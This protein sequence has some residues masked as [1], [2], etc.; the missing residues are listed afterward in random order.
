V[1]VPL[2]L[3]IYASL[4][5]L[6]AVF[7]AWRAGYIVFTG[8][9]AEHSGRLL[10]ELL[11]AAF[12]VA[13]GFGILRLRRPWRVVALVC[14]CFVFAMFALML[15]A[16]C[17]WPHSVPLSVLLVMAAA[18]AINGFFFYRFRQPDI[19]LLFDGQSAATPSV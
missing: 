6:S 11:W 4:A 12:N 18:V 3:K 14:C 5:F 16:W 1:K 7:A 17:T 15:A 2:S 9:T 19:R 8:L 13:L 10:F